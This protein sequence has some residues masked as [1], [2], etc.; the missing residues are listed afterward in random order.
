MK[1]IICRLNFAVNKTAGETTKSELTIGDIIH[2]T[3]TRI[4]D[5]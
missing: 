3:K 4:I 2:A 1:L 5:C